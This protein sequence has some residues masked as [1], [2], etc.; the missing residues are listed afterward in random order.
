MRENVLNYQRLRR[1]FG[2]TV[3]YAQYPAARSV[4]KCLKPT[5]PYR[6]V[7]IRKMHPELA[8][9]RVYCHA[10]ALC[11]GHQCLDAVC[12]QDFQ[13]IREGGQFRILCLSQFCSVTLGISAWSRLLRSSGN[14]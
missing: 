9:H 11:Q 7:M 12:V 1:I 13:T 10:A 3:E 4:M 6:S 8:H 2:R 14:V 5:G